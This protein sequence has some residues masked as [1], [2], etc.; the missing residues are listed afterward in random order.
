LIFLTFIILFSTVAA[1]PIE[2][3]SFTLLDVRFIKGVG[4][5]LLFDSTGLTKK[6]LRGGT[7]DVH[8][9]TYKMSCGFQDD[10]QTIRCVIK[11]SLVQYAGENFSGELAG[12]AFFGKIPELKESEPICSDEQV[13]WYVINVYQFGE[14]VYDSIEIPA[15][16]YDSFASFI[17]AMFEGTATLEITDTYCGENVIIEEP[18]TPA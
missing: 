1:A 8:S 17:S 11:G 16:Y 12:F 4:I 10:T 15:Q 18:Q 3:K 2:A 14:L 9:G 13:I 5:V 7:V 6:D